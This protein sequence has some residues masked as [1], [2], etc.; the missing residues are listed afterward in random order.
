[1]SDAAAFP[2]PLELV[3]A[4]EGSG[5]MSTSESTSAMVCSE[6]EQVSRWCECW[7]VT[8]DSALSV[9]PPPDA[10]TESQTRFANTRVA[11][12]V[13]KQ[14]V[15]ISQNYSVSPWL[16]DNS[17]DNYNPTNNIGTPQGMEE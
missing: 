9:L 5:A 11:R 12:L 3:V 1:M 6:E 10:H 4:V 17:Q 7:K 14:Q 2:L 16:Y 13:V 15:L 8:S